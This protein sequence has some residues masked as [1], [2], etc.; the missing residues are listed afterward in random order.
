MEALNMAERYIAVDNVCAWPNLT[1]MPDGKIVATIFNQPTHGGWEGDVECW[2]SADEGRIW[3][4]GGIPAPHEP[5]TNRMNV[6][7]GCGHD[8]ALL[9]LASGWSRRNPPGAYSSPVEGE[10]L[11][12][13]VCRSEDGGKNWDR[14]GSI[15]PPPLEK[16]DRIM[17]YGDIV[18]LPNGVLGV[19]V[20]SWSFSSPNEC[21]V[22]FYTSHDGGRTW[23]VRGIVREDNTNETTPL[24]LPDGRLLA[25][26]RTQ[27]NGHLELFNSSDGG[28]TWIPSGPVTL[29]SQ[30][31]GHLLRLK[32]G[33]LLLSY[34]IRSKGLTGIGARFSMDEGKTWD[35]PRVIVSFETAPRDCGYP[36]SVEVNDGTIVTAYYCEGIPAHQRYHMGVVRWKPDEK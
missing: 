21:N 3:R 18:R 28:A 15:V 23:N 11:P 6:A 20:Y 8:G 13:W 34:G 2:V 26:A 32:D 31:P 4:L 19:C 35:S 1:Q 17:P 12:I 36:S 16:V 29:G 22:Y 27:D 30:H 25:V 33:R 24:C 9:V 10:I 14:T 7:A 5:G